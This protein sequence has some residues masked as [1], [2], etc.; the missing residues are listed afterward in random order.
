[1]AVLDSGAVAPAPIVARAAPGATPTA[2]YSLV[3]HGGARGVDPGASS[4]TGLEQAG[5]VFEHR[6]LFDDRSL[7][8]RPPDHLRS[9]PRYIS[10]SNSCWPSVTSRRAM[11]ATA[12]FS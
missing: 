10:S 8:V 5:D 1:M 3:S 12:R 11:I 4:S 2:P 7:N 6:R 9:S